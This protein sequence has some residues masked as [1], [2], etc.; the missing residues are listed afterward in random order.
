MILATLMRLSFKLHSKPGGV[1][2]INS[3]GVL[4]RPQRQERKNVLG[5][6]PPTV[7]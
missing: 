1:E 4:M 2:F 6:E 5:V 7:A 3:V